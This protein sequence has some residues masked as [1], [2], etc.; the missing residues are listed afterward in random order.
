MH[1]SAHRRYSPK[2]SFAR[3]A[4]PRESDC[5]P[6]GGPRWIVKRDPR[7]AGE[8]SLFA[9]V[10]VCNHQ[11]RSARGRYAYECELPA[12]GGETNRCINVSDQFPR[13]SPKHWHLIKKVD[14]KILFRCAKKENIFAIRR[15]CQTPE[16]HNGGRKNLHIA[17][18][19]H[20]PHVQASLLPFPQHIHGVLTVR[21]DGY[22]PRVA[23]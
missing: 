8:G 19:G 2:L 22:R 5:F 15:K 7:M 3:Q 21:R 6:V 16:L 10:G 14:T 13:G 12:V 18:R 20:L 11:L 4:G 23:T 9:S 17:P 1:A